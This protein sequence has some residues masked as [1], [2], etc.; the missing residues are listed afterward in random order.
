MNKSY[1][2]FIYQ[3]R[4]VFSSFRIPIL[5]FLVGI[6]VYNYVRP[7]ADFCINVNINATPWGFVFLT[8]D[9]IMQMIFT[10][11]TV[12]IFCN[13]PFTEE[14]HIYILARAGKRYWVYGHLYYIISISLV[15]VLYIYLIG[16]IALLPAVDFNNGWGKI[17]GTLARTTAAEQINLQF[18]IK[19]YIIGAYS[20]IK[21][22]IYS[23]LLEWACVS[24]LGLWIYFLNSLSK[25][26]LGTITG[27]GFVLLDLMIYNGWIPRAYLFSPITLA[28]LS[29]FN[30]QNLK[31]GVTLNY[32]IKFFSA[33]LV[34]LS[35]LCIISTNL[36][37]LLTD[38]KTEKGITHG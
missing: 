9:Y 38:I 23:V 28:Q 2:V 6:L 19:D 18:E 34:L 25:K 11:C 3:I 36:T 13:A 24:W 4:R 21:A 26:P 33:S 30:G 1:R 37:F 10:A 31:Y 15:Y 7:I 27:A 22:N 20:P 17:W 8:N 14:S 29:T 12:A 35:V 5:F 32:S 16:C